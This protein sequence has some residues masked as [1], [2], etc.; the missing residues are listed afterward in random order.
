MEIQR[1]IG[2][3]I[4]MAFDECPPGNSEREIVKKAVIRTTK[5]INRCYS[6]LEINKELYDYEQVLF[7]IVQ[8]SVDHKL[9]RRSIE[10]L[11]P[12]SK[13][14]IALG[15]LAVGRRKMLCVIRFNLVRSFY[16]R[17]NLDI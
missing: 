15:G 14:G 13:C 9:R 5:W 11:I 6:W 16:L 10:E 7:P 1:N 3:D 2:A 8:G 12:F 4:I 17:I